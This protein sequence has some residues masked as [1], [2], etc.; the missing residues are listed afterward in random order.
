[1]NK[2]QLRRH[3]DEAHRQMLE[4]DTA[5]RFH[6]EELRR[7]AQEIE[8]L[9]EQLRQLWPACRDTGLGEGPRRHLGMAIRALS[10]GKPL[11]VSDA[12][13]FAEFPDAMAAKVPADEFEVTTLAAML[14]LLAK[15]DR[16]R[17]R[18]GA[19]AADYVRREHDL[20]HVADL[21]VAALEEAADWPA[22]RDAVLREVARS[23]HEV[24]M[25]AYDSELS[26]VA[27]RFN[28]VSSGIGS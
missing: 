14:E 28:E 16:L 8:Q 26:V 3:L 20:D 11:I 21:Y 12:G 4:R 25:T 18:M 23:A 13:W 2:Q 27:A 5:Y 7:R 15:D 10:L 24:G 6:E 9:A 17:E 22:V 19:A 1:M